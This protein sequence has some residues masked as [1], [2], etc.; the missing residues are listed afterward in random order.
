MGRRVPILYAPV[1]A[2]SK[3]SSVAVKE[4]CPDWYPAGRSARPRLVESDFEHLGGLF[5]RE[6]GH[7]RAVRLA[8]LAHFARPV[9]L[10]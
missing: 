6:W 7:G 9:H 5:A 3:E 10:A 8:P 4:R 2:H 1:V